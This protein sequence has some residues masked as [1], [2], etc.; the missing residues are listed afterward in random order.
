MSIVDL[1]DLCAQVGLTGD[2]P[3]E[4]MEI[5]ARKGAAAQDHIERLLGY[6]IEDRFGGEGQEPVPPALVEAV[7]QLAAWWFD[8]RETVNV[9]NIVNAVP[10]G[11]D[12]IV[13]EYRE[14]S[15]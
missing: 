10:F 11:V 4:D 14:W 3:V 15:F 5:L 1:P 9:G 13:T 2:A 12:Q 6:R 7:M 8:N